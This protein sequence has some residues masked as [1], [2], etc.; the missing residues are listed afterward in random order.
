VKACDAG[1]LLG[2]YSTLNLSVFQGIMSK[3][4]PLYR[5][6]PE[7]S[8]TESELGEYEEKKSSFLRNRTNDDYSKHPDWWDK[9]WGKKLIR[10]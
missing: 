9:W 8:M 10:R 6:K 5:M 3:N 7:S 1:F 4:H 2:T